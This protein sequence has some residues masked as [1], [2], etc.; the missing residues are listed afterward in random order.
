[1]KTFLI[2][3]TIL[4][5]SM[6][7]AAQSTF[8]HTKI[9]KIAIHKTALASD[10]LPV[11]LLHGVYFDHHL[12]DEQLKQIKDR[13]VIAIDMPLHGESR[14]IINA[15]WSLNDCAD[16][17]IEILDSLKISKVI[18][19]GHSWGSM[20]ILRAANKYPERFESIGLCNMP[21]EAASPKR[22]RTFKLQHMMLTF[23]KFYTK[24]AAKSL[25]GKSSLKQNP[26]LLK[27][28]QRSMN[29]LS[30]KDIKQTDKKVIIDAADASSLIL[31]LKVNAI[32]LKGKE[33][34][35]PTAPNI[36]TIIVEG[37]H[38]SP[39]EQPNAVLELI[40]KL[41]EQ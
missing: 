7:S 39:L 37:G 29:I 15:D 14:E 4:I 8:I 21:F 18:A 10:N 33:D 23:R 12:W 41:F 5:N 16:M 9:G 1:M 32:A 28:L 36:E 34:Y 24:Q 40:K 35:V 30:I 13:T 31:S 3:I 17:L 38:I 22:K 20:T 27:H 11:I 26:D 2:L 25:Y 6:T 19:V